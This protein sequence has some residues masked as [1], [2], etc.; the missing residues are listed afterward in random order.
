M[1][2]SQL[3]PAL[4]DLVQRVLAGVL[5]AMPRL[6]T[7]V[8]NRA[9]EATAIMREL[10]PQTGRAHVIGIT[11]APGSGK[12]TLTNELIKEFRRRGRS[13]G[14]VAVDPTSTLTGGAVLGDRIR[15]LEN[16][17]DAEVFIR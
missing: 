5:W 13:V 11:G 14:V 3:N 9:L 16:Y 7:L 15:M 17:Q 8:G 6:I 2:S 4:S 10:T 1:A 12:S